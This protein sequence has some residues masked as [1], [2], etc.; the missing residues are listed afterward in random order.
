M[1]YIDDV[2]LFIGKAREKHYMYF[3]TYQNMNSIF[4]HVK[5]QQYL[6]MMKIIIF[7]FRGQSCCTNYFLDN[8]ICKG[9]LYFN[10]ALYQRSIITQETRE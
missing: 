4:A 2:Y 1:S 9:K 5:G 6:Y 10:T 7:F 8:G 3:A